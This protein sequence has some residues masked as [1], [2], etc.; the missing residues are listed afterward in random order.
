MHR[1]LFGSL[2]LLL[3][4]SAPALAVRL[5]NEVAWAAGSRWTYHEDFHGL[6]G[7]WVYVPEGFSS[8]ADRRGLVYFFV[9]C[10]Q[11]PF[12]AAQGGGWPDAAEAYGLVVVIPTATSPA[13]PNRDA[14]NVECFNYGYDGSY[15][16]YRP[17]RND[18]DHA[19]VIAATRALI[20]D[21]DLAIDPHQVYVTGLSAG[22]AFA[23]EVACMAPD[24]FAGLATASAPGIGTAQG[25]A[26]M[27][28]QAGWGAQSERDLCLQW[29][30]ASRVPNAREL[31]SQQI[32]AISSDNN[33][34]RAG[35]GAL[36]TSLFNDQTVWDGD[37]FCP[38]IYQET[39]AQAWQGLLSLG[40]PAAGP[41]I[42][43][44][45][46]LGCPGGE[47]SRDDVGEV[48]CVIAN[49]VRRNWTTD[50]RLYRDPQG[51][52]RLAQ[53]EQD[54]LRHAWPTGP[55]GPRD[56]QPTPTRDSLR[57]DGYI[58]VQT[59]EFDRNRTRGAPHGTYGVIYLNHDAFDYPMF[60]GQLWAENNPRIVGGAVMP[61]VDPPED[62]MDPVDPEEPVS[63]ATVS[64]TNAAGS[65]D[66]CLR[67]AGRSDGAAR[68]EVIVAGLGAAD[69]ALGGNAWTYERC[70][71]AP[72][73]Y[74]HLVR[75][76]DAAGVPGEAT[77]PATAI[78]PAGAGLE[79]VEGTLTDH[80][81]AGR[82]IRF[83]DWYYALRDATCVFNGIIWDCASFP[84]YRCAGEADWTDVL[85]DCGGAPPMVALSHTVD[86]DVAVVVVGEPAQVTVGVRNAG[87]DAASA[88][89]LRA[90]LVGLTVD[91]DARCAPVDG[92]LWCHLG[93]LAAGGE[94]T[95]VLNTHAAQPGQ[96]VW[97]V[98]LAGAQQPAA[99]ELETTWQV[100]GRDAPDPPG[101]GGM[102]GGVGGMGG[103]GGAGGGGGAGGTGGQG[104]AGGSPEVTDMFE[105]NPGTDAGAPGAGG[106]RDP[107][108]PI[109]IPKDGCR[110][111]PGEPGT[112]ALLVL[113]LLVAVVR[114]RR[115]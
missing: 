23:E 46:G 24:L 52:V 33:G 57:A 36:D 31:V 89:Y 84:L 48:H 3:A 37:K 1:R 114:R 94:T 109:P 58:N 54:T 96:V 76:V 93:E 11:M 29:A 68:V 38:H 2:A 66:G 9:G 110:A 16:V 13:F 5:P 73:S 20:A 103:Q 44:G 102:G 59:G 4:L 19:A 42:A 34:L 56:T 69:A 98:G 91:G 77:A 7:A 10:G 22:G 111:A 51:R 50:V 32:V 61:P 70:G 87:P 8:V 17:S 83:T 67:V 39:R 27:P 90:A 105:E 82:V 101:A 40:A 62:P 95:V 41:A 112:P 81:N 79:T 97:A 12:Q 6:T 99:I 113:G 43:Q 35:V 85:P 55:L 47:Q 26:V 72:G 49:G 107:G 63:A 104:G 106:P 115:G 75:G 45:D 64:I 80:S 86:V 28:P 78:V 100:A 21:R 108:K 74:L 88:V 25:T 71:L 14:P 92:T 53:I 60:L 18:P 15:G 65:A 30:D